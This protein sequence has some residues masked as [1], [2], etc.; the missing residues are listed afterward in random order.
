MSRTNRAT[1]PADNSDLRCARTLPLCPT[2][3]AGYVA[4]VARTAQ[5]RRVGLLA[6]AF[7]FD[8]S[9]V[10]QELEL[11]D[12]VEIGQFEAMVIASGD[13]LGAI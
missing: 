6:R 12:L 7:G 13:L 8:F 11:S 3:R 10:Y 4:P 1:L 9:D 2:L 5:D